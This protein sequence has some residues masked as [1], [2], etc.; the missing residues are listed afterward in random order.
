MTAF[1]TINAHPTANREPIDMDRFVNAQNLER[2]RRLH[3][4]MW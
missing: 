4:R 1:L 3:T 2:F